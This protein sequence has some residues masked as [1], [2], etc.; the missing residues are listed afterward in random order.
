[1]NEPRGGGPLSRVVHRVGQGQGQ[2]EWILSPGYDDMS[3]SGG[4]PLCIWSQ[5]KH[6]CAVP[7]NLFLRCIHVQCPPHRW[8]GP[9]D[10]FGDPIPS[11]AGSRHKGE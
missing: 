4:P 7:L 3:P 5:I 10:S 2:G 11:V 8:W 6:I 1:M 9:V